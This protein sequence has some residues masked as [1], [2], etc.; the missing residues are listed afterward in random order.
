MRIPCR[1]KGCFAPA[2]FMP[3]VDCEIEIQDRPARVTVWIGVLVCEKHVSEYHVQPGSRQRIEREIRRVL[4]E[5]GEENPKIPEFKMGRQPVPEIRFPV[6][7]PNKAPEK[8][9]K[10]V[11][12]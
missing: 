3:T 8:A 2:L 9:E 7:D 6:T 12:N 1:F 5:Y 11:W 4:L 10:H